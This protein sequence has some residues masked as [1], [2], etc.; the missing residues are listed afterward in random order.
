MNLFIR[1][2]KSEYDNPEVMVLENGWSDTSEINDYD[3]IAYFREHLQQIHDV[4]HNDGCNVQAYSGFPIELI[5]ILA[6]L[7]K[8]FVN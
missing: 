3:R 2:I 1:W 7:K 4:I 8:T 5:H 6:I